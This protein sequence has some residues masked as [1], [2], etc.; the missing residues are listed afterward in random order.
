MSTNFNRIITTELQYIKTDLP[1]A[2]PADGSQTS[3]LVI[4]PNS[5]DEATRIAWPLLINTPPDTDDGPYNMVIEWRHKRRAHDDSTYLTIY[6]G[7]LVNLVFPTLIQNHAF[8]NYA[9]VVAPEEQIRGIDI[10]GVSGYPSS[11]VLANNGLGYSILA[12]EDEIE[13]YQSWTGL[14]SAVTCSIVFAIATLKGHRITQNN[15]N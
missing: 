2:G 12:P 7:Q 6:S 11:P 13:L 9:G 14:G 4:A 8:P 5:L 15:W 1:A 3:S 10:S